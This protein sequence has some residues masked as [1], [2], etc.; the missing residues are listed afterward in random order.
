MRPISKRV[1]EILDQEPDVC[2]LQVFGGC[3]GRITRE[4]ALIYA[5]K[6]IDEPWAIVKICSRH[7][8]VDEYQDGGLLDKEK[9][10]WVALN[11]ATDDQLR[12]YSKA[13][14]YIALKK[15]LNTKYGYISTCVY[16][17]SKRITK[18][19]QTKRFICS[20]CKENNKEKRAQLKD[21]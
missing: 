7:H 14:D 1:R 12:Q 6:Q 3:A 2:A 4:H 16:C 10:V 9:N 18:K 8:S 13:V 20:F 5:G 15:R 19:I 17:G 11:K 21:L